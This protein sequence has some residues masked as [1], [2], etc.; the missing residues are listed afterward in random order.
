MKVKIVNRSKHHLPSYSTD[1]SAGMDLRANIENDIA[2]NP[3]ERSLIPTGLYLEI[4]TGNP[5][6]INFNEKNKIVKCFYLDKERVQD[7][8][9]F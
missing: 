4:P 6:L 3:M 7:L 1:E 5:L 8:I 9:V 2:L